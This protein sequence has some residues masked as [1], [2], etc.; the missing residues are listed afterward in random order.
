[1]PQLEGWWH[2]VLHLKVPK[3]PKALFLEKTSGGGGGIGSPRD[4]VLIKG[5]SPEQFIRDLCAFWQAFY[6]HDVRK[7]LVEVKYLRETLR[8]GTGLSKHKDIAQMGPIP[9]FV[10]ALGEQIQPGF[11]ANGGHRLWFKV[12]PDFD[13]RTK[14]MGR[15]GGGSA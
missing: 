4:G 10:A 3:S 8:D 15:F 1:M 12:F 5:R 7:Y 2:L 6:P 14:K 13:P 9:S 11:W